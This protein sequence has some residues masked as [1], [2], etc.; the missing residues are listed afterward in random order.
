[1]IEQP[2][3]HVGNM[4]KAFIKKNR[5]SQALISRQTGLNQ[6]GILRYQKQASMRVDTLL[7]L[8]VAFQYNFLKEISAALPADMPP[9]TENP[10]QAKIAELEKQKNDLELQ[11]KTLKEAIELM[12]K[13]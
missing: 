6:R 10:L 13:K 7:K 1:M 3:V 8:S 12:G 11:V 5:V 2:K 4:L 9:L